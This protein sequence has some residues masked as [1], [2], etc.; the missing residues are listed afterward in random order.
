LIHAS[1]IEQAGG[2]KQTIVKSERTQ[3]MQLRKLFQLVL[4]AI[5]AI[6][7]LMPTG[8][9]QAKPNN[10]PYD[11]PDYPI[12]ENPLGAYPEL[13][14]SLYMPDQ[15]YAGDEFEIEVKVWNSGDAKAKH[16]ML[17]G[18]A[19]PKGYFQIHACDPNCTGTTTSLGH[20]KPNKSK[21]ASYWVTAPHNKAGDFTFEFWVEAYDNVNAY[22]GWHEI[23]VL[24]GQFFKMPPQ[25]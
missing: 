9:A 2:I 10:P 3:T 13:E 17:Y 1:H 7:L 24:G 12:V 11:T 6:G 21:W 5:A 20:I 14:C 19:T 23:S 8:I 16:V 18:K 25:Q 15:V 4:F 22:C